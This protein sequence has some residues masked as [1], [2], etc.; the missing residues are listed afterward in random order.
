MVSAIA[1]KQ[2]K[3]EECLAAAVNQNGQQPDN[4]PSAT[5]WRRRNKP[6]TICYNCGKPGHIAKDCQQEESKLI[7]CFSCRGYGHVSRDCANNLNGQGAVSTGGRL[8]ASKHFLLFIYLFRPEHYICE[9]V[10]VSYLQTRAR[11]LL[12]TVWLLF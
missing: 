4:K 11:S 7:Q 12:E 3:L 2:Q 1:C 10:H 8:T 5:P 9:I 6:P